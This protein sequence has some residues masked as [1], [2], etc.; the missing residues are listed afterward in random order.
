MRES[1]PAAP[2]NHHPATTHNDQSINRKG[3]R[4]KFHRQDHPGTRH[5]HRR[6]HR[7]RIEI[8][9]A[10]INARWKRET[11]R[12]GRT[13]IV[14]GGHP[15]RAMRDRPKW[16]RV[17]ILWSEITIFRLRNAPEGPPSAKGI[18]QRR[19]APSAASLTRDLPASSSSPSSQYVQ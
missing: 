18:R 11:A 1:E 16:H 5:R 8:W 13:W 7:R 19:R 12:D 3:Q 6:L 14:N 10:R 4:W 2:P 15:S 17:A 9:L